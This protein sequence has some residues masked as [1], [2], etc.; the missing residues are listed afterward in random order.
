MS[1]YLKTFRK[2]NPVKLVFADT[3]SPV[4]HKVYHYAF[5]CKAGDEDTNSWN[6]CGERAKQIRMQMGTAER[7]F[8]RAVEESPDGEVLV[9]QFKPGQLEVGESEAVYRTS[10]EGVYYD[11]E[12]PGENVGTVVKTTQGP[13]LFYPN[14]NWSGQPAVTEAK[15]ERDEQT[16]PM[17]S[18]VAKEFGGMKVETIDL[19]PT[20]AGI[21]PA[22]MAV[23]EHGT[24]EGKKH[25]RSELK[26][27]AEFADSHNEETE[28]EVE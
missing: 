14:D 20:W 11:T 22:L 26:R 16:A 5:C 9:M 21:L 3:K 15:R 19:T 27:L 2:S 18:D 7:G 8:V 13:W 12:A 24:E 28:S 10:N 4:D 25:V 1:V 23:L 6:R 17:R